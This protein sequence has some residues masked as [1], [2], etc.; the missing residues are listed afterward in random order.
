MVRFFI[1]VK[2]DFEYAYRLKH[3]SGR[4]HV[5]VGKRA[6]PKKDASLKL[7]LTL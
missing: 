1:L 7:P 3:V 4:V 2:F 6:M 5:V